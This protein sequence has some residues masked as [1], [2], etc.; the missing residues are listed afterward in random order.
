[1]RLT[2]IRSLFGYAALLTRARAE[3]I[4]GLNHWLVLNWLRI[5]TFLSPPRSTRCSPLT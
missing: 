1:L 5:V 3:V 4:A 2:A